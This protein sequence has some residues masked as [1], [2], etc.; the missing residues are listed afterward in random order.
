M[1]Y[2]Q[3][4]WTKN[5][6]KTHSLICIAKNPFIIRGLNII[7][8]TI[9]LV[10]LLSYATIF[11][12]QAFKIKKNCYL[13]ILSLLN[14]R[15]NTFEN[16]VSYFIHECNFT[17]CHSFKVNQFH[18]TN[19]ISWKTEHTAEIASKICLSFTTRDRK[20]RCRKM[21]ESEKMESYQGRGNRKSD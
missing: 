9:F 18:Q 8:L 19:V 4:K 12:K 11:A 6:P 10:F 7:T 16:M 3:S 15:V 1:K 21:P 17:L 2:L 20:L 13:C 14:Q 5:V